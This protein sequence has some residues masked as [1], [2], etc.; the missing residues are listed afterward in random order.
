MRCPYCQ[1][2]DTQV[3]DSRPAEDSNAIRRRRICP[4][5]GGRFTTFERV[6]LRE[7]M[8]VKK[9]GRKVLFDR[10]K[11]HR[12]F[13]IALRKRPVDEDRVER[14]VS[15]IVRQLESMGEAEISSPEIGPMVLEALKRIDHVAFVRYASVYKDFADPQDFRDLI[16]EL[17][18]GKPNELSRALLMGAAW[19]INLAVAEWIIRK[20][21]APRARADSVIISRV[22]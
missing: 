7:L 21:K 16:G 3:K 4:D 10:E 8:V 5:C 9:S 6:Q 13:E 20:P 17:I 12:S 14:A 19:V 18:A 1:S 2:P 22:S 15:G 11:L